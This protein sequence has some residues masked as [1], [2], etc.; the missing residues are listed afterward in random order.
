MPVPAG[1]Q[2]AST[3]TSPGSI[4]SAPWPL[5]AAIAAASEANTRA[6]PTWRYTPSVQQ[7]GV[8]RRGLHHGDP[9]REVARW[10]TPAC[11]GA[12]LLGAL[13]AERSRRRGRR[14]RARGAVREAA[15]GAS[16]LAHA[17]STSPSGSPV[18][19]S[20]LRVEQAEF[21]QVE[22]HLG[23]AAG[24]EDA[25]R[26]VIDRAVGQCAHQPRRA[27]DSRRSSRAPSAARS[28]A[29]WATAGMCEQQIRRAAKRRVHDHR[30]ADRR[31]RSRCRALRRPRSLCRQHA[32]GRASGEFEPD[33]LPRRRERRVRQRQAER[34][35]DDLRRGRRAEELAAA[36]RRGAGAAAEL[37]R[38]LQRDQ[39][40]GRSARRWFESCPRLRRASAAATRRRGR[41]P[42]AGRACRPA[43]SSSPDGPCRRWRRR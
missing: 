41:A 17:S 11:R 15:R 18:A 4:R 34:F 38:F 29:A 6:G 13:A 32:C 43:P 33:R 22:H 12:R 9:R 27:C 40:R 5:I 2:P 26:R 39:V 36:A 1:P 20:T 14:R 28:P 31:R 35:A 10:E 30:V 16:E 3:S 7:R 25:D 24:E 37:G 21:A 8:D 19:V 42:P 23:H